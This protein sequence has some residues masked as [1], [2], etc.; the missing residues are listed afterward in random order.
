M[1]TVDSG[2][3][4]LV[5]DPDAPAVLRDLLVRARDDVPSPTALGAVATHLSVSAAQAASASAP[6]AMAGTATWL[7]VPGKVL[8]STVL[9]GAVVGGS[10]YLTRTQSPRPTTSLALAPTQGPSR[11]ATHLDTDVPPTARA[12]K[13]QP[14]R[15]RAASQQNPA[16]VKPPPPKNAVASVDLQEVRLID[17]ARRILVSDATAALSLL[18]QHRERFPQG[19]LTEEREVLAVESLLGLGRRD[20]ARVRATAFLADFPTSVQRRRLEAALARAAIEIRP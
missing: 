8:L 14:K 16:E 15:P 5:G 13:R 20:E 1:T 2:P 9:M 6:V 4:R 17:A 11:Q 19:A 7:G 12:R 18:Q 3:R 10:L